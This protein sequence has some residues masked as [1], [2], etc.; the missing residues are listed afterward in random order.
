MLTVAGAIKKKDATAAKTA[1][2]SA[3]KSCTTC[4]AA[5]RD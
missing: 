5:F 4:H 1:Y 2:L 3:T